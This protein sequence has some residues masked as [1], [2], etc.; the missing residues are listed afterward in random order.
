[1]RLRDMMLA[2]LTSVIWGF[3]FVTYKFGLESFSAAQLT[4]M[5]FLIA[6]LPVFFVP[7]PKLPWWLIALIGLILF[8]GQFLLLLMA[9]A[10]DM[11]AGL[12]SVTQQMQAGFTVALAAIFLREFPPLRQGVCMTVAFAGLALIGLTIGAD[13][14]PAALG[15]A[16]AATLCWAVGNL[17]VKRTGNAPVFPLMAW[18][19]LV[20]TVPVLLFSYAVDPQPSLVQAIVH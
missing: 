3:A 8:G 17:L 15:L 13:L 7:R 18:C 14:R 4:V 20:A 5:R 9:F 2:V 11:P 1:M 6:A 16:L 19:S 10:L 12:G